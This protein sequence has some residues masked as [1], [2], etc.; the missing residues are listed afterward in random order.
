MLTP[1]PHR[2]LLVILALSLLGTKSL[3]AQT[4]YVTNTGKKYHEDNCRYL[5]NS[6]IQTTLSQALNGGYTACS[7]CSPPTKVTS[8]SSSA[9]IKKAVSVQCSGT[10]KAGARCK[11]MTTN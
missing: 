11:R 9:P 2:Q 1:V 5:K 4:V 8:P 6:K 3:L 7:V 10:T